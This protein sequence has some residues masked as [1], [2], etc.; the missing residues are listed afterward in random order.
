MGGE[1]GMAAQMW[2]A[3]TTEARGE[4]MA[5]QPAPG[6]QRFMEDDKT[7]HGANERAI[8]AAKGRQ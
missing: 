3:G 2:R 4:H 6:W 5:A 8:I 7:R 1:A